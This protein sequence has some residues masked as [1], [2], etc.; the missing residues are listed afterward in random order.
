[1]VGP[2][3]DLDIDFV[4][5]V[6]DELS[7]GSLNID[8]PVFNGVVDFYLSIDFDLS[9]G[10][11]DPEIEFDSSVFNNNKSVVLNSGDLN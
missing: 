8:S 1:V 11:L 2:V 9:N 4:V 10:L 5:R 3:G 6:D 7:D